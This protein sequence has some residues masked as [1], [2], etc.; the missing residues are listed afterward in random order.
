MPLSLIPVSTAWSGEESS[1]NDFKLIQKVITV[2]M[3]MRILLRLEF[4]THSLLYNAD[5]YD[6]PYCEKPMTMFHSKRHIL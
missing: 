6:D 5:E 1:C 3:E 2:M 4:N